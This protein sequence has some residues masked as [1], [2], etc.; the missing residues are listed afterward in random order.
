MLESFAVLS[1]D[2]LRLQAR[3]NKTG[4]YALA[5]A[6]GLSENLYS[7][8]EEM[9]GRYIDGLLLSYAMW[10]NHARILDFFRQTV[11]QIPAGSKVREI[12]VGHGLMATMLHR[13]VPEV[14]YVGIDLSPH[15]IAYCRQALAEEFGDTDERWQFVEADATSVGGD[16]GDWFVCCEVLEHVD[17][18]Q[19]LLQSC[20]GLIHGD[21]KGF[22]TTVANLEAEDHVYLFNDVG[23]IRACL[24]EA[25]FAVEQELSLVL[26]G[27]E[28]AN[29]LPLNYAAVVSPI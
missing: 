6:E 26:P 14:E 2:F 12:G 20:R 27:S 25:G 16:P 23:H 17:R 24:D 7:D 1:F 5:S 8:G 29:P 15:T 28:D 13:E 19:D 22:L 4:Q 21:G 18:P 11:A 9:L 3:F 10:P